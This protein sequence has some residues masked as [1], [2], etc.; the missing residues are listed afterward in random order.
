VASIVM[1]Y[2]P[3]FY[4]AAYLIALVTSAATEQW[5]TALYLTLLYMVGWIDSI[6][7]DPT[8]HMMADLAIFSLIIFTSTK[9]DGLTL[10]IITLLMVMSSGVFVIQ[11]GS[12][13]YRLS[14]INILFLI[15]CLIAIGVGI[16]SHKTPDKRNSNG[17]YMAKVRS[18]GA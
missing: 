13:F 14:I 4:L 17:M 16:M 10:S 11:G 8:T 9:K 7:Y 6:W 3:L 18:E 2:L 15:Q 12:E 1:I 5:K